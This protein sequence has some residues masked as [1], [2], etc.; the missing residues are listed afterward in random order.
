[1]ARA[2]AATALNER[3]NGLFGRRIAIGAV[4]RTAADD[5]FVGLDGLVWAA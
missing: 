5:G 4:L 2:C 1:M 3:E